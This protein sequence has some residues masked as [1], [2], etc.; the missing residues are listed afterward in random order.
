MRQA[1]QAPRNSTWL[2]EKHNRR[3]NRNPCPTV[4]NWIV[5]PR[6][7]LA[8]V[9]D[10]TRWPNWS[11]TKSVNSAT[12]EEVC[13]APELRCDEGTHLPR[14]QG[15]FRLP[16]SLVQIKPA[17]RE[18]VHPKFLP[19]TPQP[20]ELTRTKTASHACHS[21]GRGSSPIV[22]AIRHEAPLP[23][24]SGGLIRCPLMCK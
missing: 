2:G 18:T 1:F 8:P 13:R 3:S 12:K 19:S 10:R 5:S 14:E 4:A 7:S 15:R 24:E 9:Y 22:P 17:Q 11:V 16:A 21:R 20:S 6:G 23:G